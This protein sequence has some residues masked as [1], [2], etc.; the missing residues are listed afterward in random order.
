MIIDYGRLG[1]YAA[2]QAEVARVTSAVIPLW[3]LALWAAIIWSCP[4]YTAYSC[5]QAY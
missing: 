2:L 5:I 3:A 1:V 4:D